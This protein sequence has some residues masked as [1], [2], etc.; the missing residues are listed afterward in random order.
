MHRL[1]E[2]WAGEILASLWNAIFH[3]DEWEWML[4]RKWTRCCDPSNETFALVC[5]QPFACCVESRDRCP[6][7]RPASDRLHTGIA[8]SPSRQAAVVYVQGSLGIARTR[9]AS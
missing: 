2:V 7:V 3:N 8:A 5:C 4:R 6:N 9:V 1:H